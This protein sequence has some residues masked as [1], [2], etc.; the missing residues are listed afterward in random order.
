MTLSRIEIV[1]RAKQRAGLLSTPL[2]L[3]QEFD[4]LLVD[5]SGRYYVL[6]NQLL[7]G[8]TVDEQA[9]QSEAFPPNYMLDH[10]NERMYCDG[11]LLTRLELEEYFYNLNTSDEVVPGSPSKYAIDIDN[12][13][14]YF[15]TTPDDTYAYQFYHT[16][17]HP[18]SGRTIAFT[19]GGTYE[20]RPGVT[21][22]GGTSAATG[23]VIFVKLT[24]G[25]WAA[26]TA[27]GNLIFSS[28]SGTFTS[29]NL[30]VGA[31]L[32]VATVAGNSSSEDSFEHLLGSRFDDTLVYGL[33]YKACELTEPPQL[34]KSL[35]WKDKYERDL[36]TKVIIKSSKKPSARPSFWQ[37]NW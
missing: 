25:T 1:V 2:N 5:I 19:S 27:A 33:T 18:K 35:F 26:G 22:T 6:R 24:S 16:I 14:V 10:G 8:T 20:I 17:S 12:S 11:N 37:S 4:E 29:E 30:N 23:A 34:E 21:V 9:Y 13:K 7:S 15:W 28:Q 3:N 32:N 36:I 31:D